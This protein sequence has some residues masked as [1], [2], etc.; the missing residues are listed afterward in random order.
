MVLDSV[1][2]PELRLHIYEHRLAEY[3]DRPG[4]LTQRHSYNNRSALTWASLKTDPTIRT[5][6]PAILQVEMGDM[7]SHL[8]DWLAKERSV[9]PVETYPVLRFPD[10]AY[11]PE[12]DIIYLDNRNDIQR[13]N[14][15]LGS[16]DLQPADLQIPEFAGNIRRVAIAASVRRTDTLP[17]FL[18]G[19][20][21]LP[22]LQELLVVFMIASEPGKLE[23]ITSVPINKY[24]AYALEPIHDHDLQAQP[25]ALAVAI[26]GLD[27]LLRPMFKIHAES[28]NITACKMIPRPEEAILFGT[29]SA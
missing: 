26:E 6:V 28:L 22:G 20:D 7:R 10:R 21:K 27:D 24:P 8:L 25:Q 1:L 18:E 15:I 4:V 2:P 13:L 16:E 9:L 19:L 14:Y 3:F 23:Y 12:R 29:S 11:E 17:A 5:P